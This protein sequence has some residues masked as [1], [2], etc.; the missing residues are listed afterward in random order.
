MFLPSPSFFQ[1]SVCSFSPLPAF[2]FSFLPSFL[3]FISAHPRSSFAFI[4]PAPAALYSSILIISQSE[5]RARTANK[6]YQNCPTQCWSS[7]G[8]LVGWSVGFSVGFS[9]L[10]LSLVT[11]VAMAEVDASSVDTNKFSRHLG[12][13]R[14]DNSFEQFGYCNSLEKE[15]AFECYRDMAAMVSNENAILVS[16]KMALVS[17]N[18]EL[19]S[20]NAAMASTIAKLQSSVET[21]EPSDGTHL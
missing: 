13:N 9:A 1:P 18:T 15:E 3:D 21:E 16:A 10:L 4:T 20:K 6:W 12:A 8:S 5:E 7:F 19:V 2:V 17:E 11:I 14:T